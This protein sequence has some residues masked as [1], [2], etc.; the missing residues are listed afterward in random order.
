MLNCYA[1]HQPSPLHALATGKRNTTSNVQDTTR[2][3]NLRKN[4]WI[5]QQ[6][7]GID[8]IRPYKNPGPNNAYRHE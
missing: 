8:H 7:C 1:G 3:L 5:S 2:A 6:Q 4:K